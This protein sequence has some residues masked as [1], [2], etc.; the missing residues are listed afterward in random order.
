MISPL[1]RSTS[2]LIFLPNGL[3][4][5]FQKSYFASEQELD[6]QRVEVSLICQQLA[7]KH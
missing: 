3:V 7:I 5:S 4:P 6:V 1:T 2:N